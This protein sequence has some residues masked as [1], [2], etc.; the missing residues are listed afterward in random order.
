[1]GNKGSLVTPGSEVPDPD[2]TAL[3]ADQAARVESLLPMIARRLFTM[4][5]GHPLA[6]MP[7]AQLRLCALL[8]GQDSPTMSQVAD[9]LRISV[10][11]V[12]QLAD[13][14]ERAGLVERVSSDQVANGR[15]SERDRRARHLRLTV[16]GRELML[17]RRTLR[18]QVTRAALG[19]LS[20]EE[21]QAAVD[22]LEM[23]LEV[24]Q[25]VTEE[26]GHTTVRPD[27]ETRENMAHLQ[28]RGRAG[29][30]NGHSALTAAAGADPLVPSV[31]S[32]ASA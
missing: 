5:P 13:R 21:R 3:I 1:M 18:Q 25:A 7:V 17:S 29:R 24:S 12:T 2:D 11:A 20:P 14:L 26:P 9:E 8:L 27:A 16:K 31:A 32:D 28:W 19:L 23:L 15:G 4:D 30:T 10:S 22:V 6:E